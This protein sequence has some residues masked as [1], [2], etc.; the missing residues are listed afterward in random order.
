MRIL[1][2]EGYFLVGDSCAKPFNTKSKYLKKSG[3]GNPLKNLVGDGD[4]SPPALVRFF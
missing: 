4:V 1:G 3:G 2:E